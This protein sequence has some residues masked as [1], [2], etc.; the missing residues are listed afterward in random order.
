M[1]AR[2]V[3]RAHVAKG[4]IPGVGDDGELIQSRTAAAVQAERARAARRAGATGGEAKAQDAAIKAHGVPVFDR[5]AGQTEL[6]SYIAK[7]RRGR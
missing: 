1:P 7:G 2:R 5:R 4:N 3:I 6:N